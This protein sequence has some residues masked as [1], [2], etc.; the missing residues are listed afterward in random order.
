MTSRK[1]EASLGHGGDGDGLMVGLADPRGLFPPL[2][3]P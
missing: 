2:L 3:S 1:A